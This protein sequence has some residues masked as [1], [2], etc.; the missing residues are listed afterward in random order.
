VNHHHATGVHREHRGQKSPRYEGHQADQTAQPR[1]PARLP[2]L[3]DHVDHGE[4]DE[5][6]DGPVSERP[7]VVVT[8]APRALEKR[9][10]RILKGIDAHPRREREPQRG[11]PERPGVSEPGRHILSST[12]TGISRCVFFA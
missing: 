6:G 3:H 7:F 9:I 4:L 10:V 12:T 8:I 2:R 5:R 11:E 1:A